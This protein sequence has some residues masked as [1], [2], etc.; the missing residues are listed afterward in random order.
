MYHAF[1]EIV[2]SAVFEVECSVDVNSVMMDSVLMVLFK[3]SISLWIFYNI[4][5][6]C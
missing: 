2:Y 4:K 5:M 6:F 1:E 3:S